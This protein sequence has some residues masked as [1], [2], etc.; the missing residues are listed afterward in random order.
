M[1]KRIKFRNTYLLKQICRTRM[2]SS[3]CKFVILRASLILPECVSTP[4]L[5]RKLLNPPV[6]LKLQ[7]FDLLMKDGDGV[8]TGVYGWFGSL[9]YDVWKMFEWLKEET[10]EWIL[11]LQL[12]AQNLHKW[13]FLEQ[14]D[15][16]LFLWWFK[17]SNNF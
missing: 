2:S 9:L 3:R 1:N 5:L 16:W 17:G 14:T 4:S 13:N 6:W 11:I 8:A 15:S 12:K 10:H 7:V